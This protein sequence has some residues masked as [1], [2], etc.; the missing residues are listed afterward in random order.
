MN[1]LPSFLAVLLF[2]VAAGCA[3]DPD[4]VQTGSAPQVE[5]E[6]PGENATVTGPT[7]P[8]HIVVSGEQLLLL[9]VFLKHA[10]TDVLLFAAE[11]SID[12]PAHFVYTANPTINQSTAAPLVLNVIAEG[13]NGRRS[14]KTVTFNY[15]P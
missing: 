1:R 15:E 13:Y 9:Q 14:N 3:K 4:P 11:P 2:V 12:D 5:I 10:D 8:I 6:L 7:V